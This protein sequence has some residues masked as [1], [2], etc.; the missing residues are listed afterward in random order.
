VQ[1]TGDML[2]IFNWKNILFFIYQ[3]N[4][5]ISSFFKYVRVFLFAAMTNMCPVFFT[6]YF[7]GLDPVCGSF[8]FFFFFLLFWFCPL[9]LL[10]GSDFM[11]PSFVVIFPLILIIYMSNRQQIR[12]WFQLSWKL[13][14][15]MTF[16][17]WPIFFWC[18]IVKDQRRANHIRN[19]LEC[20]FHPIFLR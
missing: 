14:F 18:R 4:L 17:S 12:V 19:F 15:F 9:G 6:F 8:F 1:C 16:C 2:L 13:F 7:L 20:M 10:T 11:S 5:F 3:W